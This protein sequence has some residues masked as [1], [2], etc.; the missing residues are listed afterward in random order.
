MTRWRRMARDDSGQSLILVMMISILTMMLVATATT[1][2]TTQIRPA[3]ASQDNNAALAAAEA[4]IEDF[5]AWVNQNCPP[6][7][8]FACAA[9]TTNKSASKT[10][11]GADGSGTTQSFAWQVLYT[12]PGVARVKSTG[13]VPANAARTSYL[14]K[15]LVADV[16]ATP[17]FNN[18]EY[19][20]KYETYSPDFINS[21]Y[22]PRTV[23][24]T[25]SADL[26]NSQLSTAAKPGK[27]TW[28]GVCS[29]LD[30][31]TTPT[32]DPTGST[33]ICN[34][35]YYASAAGTGRGTDAAWNN[36]AGRRPGAATQSAMGTGNSFAYYREGGT[37]QS[38]A[39]SEAV[40]HNDTCDSSFEPNMVMNGPIYSQDAYLIDRGKDTGNSK[41]SMPIFDN[42]AY[43]LWNG[44]VNGA[45]AALGANGGYDR[46]YTGTD[47]QIDTSIVPTPVYTSNELELPENADGAKALAT[48][49]YTGPTRILVKGSIAHVTSP[50]TTAG[51]APC[52]QS[53]GAFSAAAGGGVVDAHVPISSSLIYV[54]NPATNAHPAA[55]AAN[56]IF[57]LTTNLTVPANSNGDTLAGMWTD[58]AT[59][60]PTASCPAPADATKRRNFDCEASTTH[61]D[62]FAAIRS[63]VDGVVA[64]SS[65][66][67]ADVQAHLKTAILAPATGLSSAAFP[68]TIPTSL[69]PGGVYYTLTVNALTSAA[70]AAI[71]PAAMNSSDPF[72]QSTSGSGYTPTTKSWAITITR[73][74]CTRN[75]AC[76]Q[77]QVDSSP[78]ISGAATRTTNAADSPVNSTARW[79]WFGK[80]SGDAGYD[81]AKTYTDPNNDIT[82]YPSGY[83]DVYIEGKLTGNL[84]VVAEH[85]IVVTNDLTYNKPDLSATTDGMALVADHNVRIYRPMTCAH[86]GTA[87]VTSPGVCPDDLSG[88][89]TQPQSWPLPDNFPSNLYKFDN[90][91]SLPNG[92]EGLLYA[93]VFT[94][95]GSFMI[96][97]FYRGAIGTSLST[98]GG[99]Y[100]Y[101]RGP[102]SLPYQGRPYQ[103]STTKMPG[104]TLTYNYDNMRAGEA[105]NG[106]LRVPWLPPPSGSIANRTW[107]VVALSTGS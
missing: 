90:A 42:Y 45:M 21:F 20:T 60:S 97:N 27:I 74:T 67:D 100:Q 58:N 95:R 72:F 53:T 47:G 76:G 63:A 93:T 78:L 55:T 33:E 48:C 106:G 103:G 38:G 31:I 4:G 70:G 79:P 83:G 75:N 9:L 92:G 101:H 3:K 39:T 10:V 35:F 81:A 6:T 44:S 61:P 86:D 2:L 91:P 25:S 51:A 56:R 105:P 85:D 11:T 30:V 5:I 16:D 24:I 98:F 19:Y 87:G 23:E 28:Q 29:Y 62:L 107:N 43:T 94:L 59:Y 41:N 64:D 52:Y 82:Q 96:D 46:A 40:V 88:T 7:S 15:T 13:K 84:S 71:T 65:V 69:A 66:A 68:T 89:Y 12:V 99:L 102:T 32:C 54:Q 26:R 18:F 49:V 77:S 73:V 36:T 37:Y 1:A 17:S 14:T 22:G 8:G 104:M 34:D 80:Q 57:D 50:G